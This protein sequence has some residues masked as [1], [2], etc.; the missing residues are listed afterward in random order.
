MSEAEAE[1][2]VLKRFIGRY[3]S[4]AGQ[5]ARVV[6]AH[7]RLGEI[8]GEQGKK[9]PAMKKSSVDAYKA[10]VAAQGR[11]GTDPQAAYFAAKAAFSLAEDDFAAYERMKIASK[12]AKNQVKELEAKSKKLTEVEESYKRVITTYKSAEWSLAS[13]YR[14]GSLYDNMQKVVLRSPCPDDIKRQYGDIGCDEYANAVEDNAFNVSQKAIANFQVAYDKAK[15]LKLTNV[16]TK[17]TL[18]DLNLL[19]PEKYPIDKEPLAPAA[20][21]TV[22]DGLGLV[23]PDGGAPELKAL[24]AGP[25]EQRIAGGT[26]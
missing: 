17:R 21:G 3:G 18:E 26:K 20:D 15:E 5:G 25:A 9:S 4:S 8:Y 19:N 1:A 16:W 10:A 11:A 12:S 24:G 7:A 6:E 23:L 2:A 13:L 22:D 14:I